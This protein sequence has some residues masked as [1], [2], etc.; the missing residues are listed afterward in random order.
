MPPAIVSDVNKSSAEMLTAPWADEIAPPSKAFVLT[1]RR[2]TPT[3]TATPTKPPPTA[4]TRPKTFSL[5][6]AWTA[7]P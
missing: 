5:E 4:M 7:T 1:V 2:V 3:G 6:D